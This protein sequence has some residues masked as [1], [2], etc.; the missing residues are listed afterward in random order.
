MINLLSLS[1]N[2]RVGGSDAIRR[3]QWFPSRMRHGSLPLKHWLCLSLLLASPAMA[4]QAQFVTLGTGGG[5]VVQAKRSQPANAVVIG[6]AIYLF[7]TGEGTQR[8]LQAAGLQ[9]GQVRAIFLSHHHI[10]HVGGLGPLLVSRWAQQMFTP[11]PVIGPPG[12]KAMIDGIVTAAQPV[13]SAPLLLGGGPPHPV[14]TTVVA[15]DLPASLPVPTEVFHDANIRV[16]AII[17]DHYHRVDGSVSIAAQSYAYRIEA[18]GRSMVF[19]GDTGPSAGLAR[20]AANADLLVCEVMDRPAIVAAFA[21]TPMPS[22]A[23]A[24]FMRHMDLDHLTPLE[25]GNIAAHAHVKALVLTHLVPGR[26]GKRGT[27]GYTAGIAPT[28]PGPVT[29]ASDGDRF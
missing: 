15:S 1:R 3:L 11:V 8:Q 20:L 17:V 12:T 5:P 6:N 24:G 18:G 9:L 2:R 28:Y 26:D 4:E 13:E 27:A 29:V 22:A 10:D 25:V 19:S 7:D 23:R 16:S 21:A 14:A